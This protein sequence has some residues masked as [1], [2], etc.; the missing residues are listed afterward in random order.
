MD[1][2]GTLEVRNT[3][4]GK[5]LGR[6][7]FIGRKLL[8]EDLALKFTA[9]GLKPYCRNRKGC[10]WIVTLGRED[11]GFIHEKMYKKATLFLQRKRDLI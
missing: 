8:M 4:K 6:V 2:D 5:V 10:L 11:S 1:G 9:M 3:L 7:V